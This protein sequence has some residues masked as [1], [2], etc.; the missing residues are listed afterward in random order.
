MESIERLQRRINSLQELQTIV[1]TMKALSAVSVQQYDLAVHSLADYYRTVELGLNVVLGEMADQPAPKHQ[2]RQDRQLGVIIFGSDH[3]LCGRFNEEIA[4]YASQNMAA[5]PAA[6][7]G[8]RILAVGA[9]AAANLEQAGEVIEEDFQVPGSADRITATVQQILLK[10]DEWRTEEGIGEIYLYYNRHKEKGYQP[11]E[12]QLLPVKLHEFRQ[13]AGP[14]P[15]RR[16]PTY[17]MPRKQLL[18]ALL[19]QYFF[20][21]IFRACAESQASEHTSRLTAMQAADKNLG[22]KL[23]EITTLFHRLRQETITTEL[24]DIVSGYETIISQSH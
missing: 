18:S 10:I 9:R 8:K 23:D 22:E 17:N 1:R 13:Q 3:G 24:L 21:A 16:L 7:Q 4:N 14:W 5:L 2:R 11:T 19:R 12:L 15:S 6:T 20:V